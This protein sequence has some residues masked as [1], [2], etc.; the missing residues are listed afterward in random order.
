MLVNGGRVLLGTSGTAPKKVRLTA[1]HKVLLA[2][3]LSFIQA[4]SKKINGRAPARR[5]TVK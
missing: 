4:L 5:V 3:E 2:D 1:I